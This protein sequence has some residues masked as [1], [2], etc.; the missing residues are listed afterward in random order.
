MFGAQP[1]AAF[2]TR[3]MLFEALSFVP[4]AMLLLCQQFGFPFHLAK[5]CPRLEN[6]E[7]LR[8]GPVDFLLLCSGLLQSAAIVLIARTRPGILVPASAGQCGL[9]WLQRP[10]GQA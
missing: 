2:A 7:Q 10:L 6:F 8:E 5:T 9:N 3:E 1:F 4:E